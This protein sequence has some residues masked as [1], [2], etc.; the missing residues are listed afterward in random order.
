VKQ[1]KSNILPKMPLGESRNVDSNVKLR[2]I[3]I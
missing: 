2:W 1:N 3:Q